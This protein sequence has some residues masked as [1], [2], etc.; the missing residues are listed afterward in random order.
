LKLKECFDVFDY[1]KGG[2]IS[3][4]E[5]TST[6]KALGL[7][8]DAAKILGLVQAHSGGEAIDFEGFL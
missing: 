6:I 1:D 4:D 3:I 8:K 5:L 7:D 2:S